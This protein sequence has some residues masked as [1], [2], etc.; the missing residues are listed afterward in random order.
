MLNKTMNVGVI[1]LSMG[2]LHAEGVK[3][4]SNSQFL[5]N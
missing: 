5:L 2:K 4:V 3:E 1:G